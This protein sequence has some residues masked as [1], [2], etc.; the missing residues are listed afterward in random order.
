MTSS[1]YRPSGKRKGTW[2]TTGELREA[3]AK[4]D[5]IFRDKLSKL[6][7]SYHCPGDN[8]DYRCAGSMASLVF[9]TVRVATESGQYEIVH[10]V[11][12]ATIT[13][14]MGHTNPVTLR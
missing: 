4:A 14:T 3:M 13:C 5:R 6:R 9:D 2:R 11:P 12:R 7:T 10:D 8:N 1:I